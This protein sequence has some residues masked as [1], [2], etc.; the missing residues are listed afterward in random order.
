MVLFTNLAVFLDSY[1]T[2]WPYFRFQ[3]QRLFNCF[4]SPSLWSCNCANYKSCQIVCCMFKLHYEPQKNGNKHSWCTNT[5]SGAQKA[6]SIFY[7]NWPNIQKPRA[8]QVW[9]GVGGSES[10]QA[11]TVVGSFLF[12]LATFIPI[13]ATHTHTHSHT[14]SSSGQLSTCHKLAKRKIEAFGKLYFFF[15]RIKMH[16]LTSNLSGNGR[17]LLIAVM[18]SV[19]RN[20]K[21]WIFD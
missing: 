14:W 16:L 9:R 10:G 3:R 5:K 1:A 19:Q 20:K 6:M 12:L 18:K 15:V 17:Y 7:S 8:A 11:N 2:K 4:A 21:G 13:A